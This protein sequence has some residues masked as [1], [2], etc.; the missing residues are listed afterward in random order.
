ME[1]IYL[2]FSER[3]LQEFDGLNTAREICGQPDLWLKTFEHLNENKTHTLSF[4][5][6]AYSNKNLQIILTGAGSSAFIGDILEGLFQKNTNHNARAVATT[7]LV[8]HPEN[9][10]NKHT[11][12]LMVS[13][14]RSGNSPESLA[15]IRLADSICEKIYH[16]VI[17]CNKDGDIIDEISP[18]NSLLLLLPPK[19]NDKGLAMTGSFTSMV[20]TGYLISKIEEISFLEEQIEHLAES[21]Q[22][23][24]NEYSKVLLDVAKMDFTR[25]IFLGSGP[26]LGS[27]REAH[28]KLQE[29]TSGMVICKHDSFLGLRHGPKAVIDNKS[30]LIYM[31]SNEPYIEQY[32]AD[33]IQEI[34]NGEKGMCRIG[35]G[36]HLA[37]PH[38]YNIAIELGQK[39]SPKIDQD[40]LPIIN[41][42][43]AQMLA[44]F[45]SYLLGL[46]P[47]SPSL[48]G[49]ISR[50]VKGVNLYPYKQNSYK[51]AT[52]E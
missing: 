34:D 39:N 37:T 12:T 26:L 17:T 42:L 36:E 49:A 21:A 50:V 38:L 18:E 15:T 44:F 48:N 31:C 27:A 20:L 22:K 45:K 13:F 2:G 47:D 41:V 14:A 46:S 11:P 25:A 6:R 29:L 52:S 7:N 16:I 43:P 35:I 51:E 23:V 5:Q 40:L 33:F 4:L 28:L 8:T 30:L 24:L 9:Y 10:L 1:E 3:E 19:A 32:E